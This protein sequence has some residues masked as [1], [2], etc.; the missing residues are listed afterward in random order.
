MPNNIETVYYVVSED[1]SYF[2]MQSAHVEVWGE[3]GEDYA[4]RTGNPPC[5]AAVKQ[6]ISV[7]DLVRFWMKY[8]GTL[9]MN[10][11]FDPDYDPEHG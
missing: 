5:S 10:E 6:S 9:P 2:D 1:E 11:E 4:D 8:N 3:K 7:E